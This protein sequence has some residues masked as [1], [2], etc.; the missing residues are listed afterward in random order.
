MNDELIQLES[1]VEPTWDGLVVP[2]ERLGDSMSRAWSQISHLKAVRDNEAL[3]E[4]HAAFQPKV[5][6]MS[7]KVGTQRN[8]SM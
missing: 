3:R 7:L 5:V 6:A 2:Y 8:G 1:S 4:A